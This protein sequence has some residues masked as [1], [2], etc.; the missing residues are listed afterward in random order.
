MSVAISGKKLF[1]ETFEKRKQ[2]KEFT[3]FTSPTLINY[4]SFIS[5]LDKMLSHNINRDFFSE[6]I[7]L[8]ELQ[9]VSEGVVERK[10]K[11]TLTLLEEWL[12]KNYRL[13]H[14]E[15]YEKLLAPF[16]QVRSERQKP[17]HKISENHYD[18]AFFRKQMDLMKEVYFSISGLRTILQQHPKAKDIE[19]PDWIKDGNIKEF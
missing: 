17:A 6:F 1:R 11:G 8:Y 5:L 13:V 16:K 9:K 3:F 10:Q 19:I 18:K 4:E 14:E 2:P 7:E 15:G 12:R